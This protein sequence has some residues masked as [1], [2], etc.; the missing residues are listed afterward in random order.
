MLETE[1]SLSTFFHRHVTAARDALEVPLEPTAEH[2]VVT[3]LVRL[4]HSA[5]EPP[6]HQPLVLQ[7]RDALEE[8]RTEMRFLRFRGMGDSA[9]IRCG[10]FPEEHE[11]RG[12]RDD[13][14]GGLGRH[15]YA[16]AARAA[17]SGLRKA[18]V[19]DALADS[20]VHLARLLLDLRERV[21]QDDGDLVR[22]EAAVR[23]GGSVEAARRL[24]RL[25]LVHASVGD[26]PN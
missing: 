4:A 17:P 16:E 14:V 24:S 1:P 15:A 19:F 7:W 21:R 20:F 22:L 6:M 25:G 12:L 23:R 13:Y 10:L 2:Y 26:D 5:D 8:R 11:A 18:G 3:L 9:L